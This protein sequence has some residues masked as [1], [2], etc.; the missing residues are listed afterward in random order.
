MDSETGGD[1]ANK[2]SINVALFYLECGKATFE[3]TRPAGQLMV[4]SHTQQAA[5]IQVSSS[6]LVNKGTLSLDRGRPAGASE[7]FQAAAS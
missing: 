6:R 5:G 1:A 7:R 3:D 2:Q 4:S